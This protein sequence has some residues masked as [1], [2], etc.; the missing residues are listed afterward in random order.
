MMT[1]QNQAMTLKLPR[2]VHRPLKQLAAARTM[3]MYA[4]IAR[5]ILKEIESYDSEEKRSFE[6]SSDFQKPTQR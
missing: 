1:N 6:K 4:L 2:E 5:L 3:P